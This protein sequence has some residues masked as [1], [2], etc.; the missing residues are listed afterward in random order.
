MIARLVQSRLLRLFSGTVIDQAMLSAVNFLVGLLLIRYTTDADYAS[1]VLVQTA[2]M[3]LVSLQGAW[4]GGPLAV[5]APQLPARER[6]AM[7]STAYFGQRR[8]GRWLLLV[9]A[10]SALGL[11]LSGDIGGIGVTIFAAGSL[12][13]WASMEREFLRTVLLID[14]RAPTLLLVDGLYVLV[15][16]GGVVLAI[17]SPTAAAT[18]AVLAIAIASMAAARLTRRIVTREP[19][20]DRRDNR[21]LW[22]QLR[23]LGGWA[24]AGVVVYWSFSQGYNYLLVLM[25][26]VGAVA[27]VAATRLLLMPVNLL[28][29]GVKNLLVPTVAGWL[30]E[31]GLPTVMRRLGLFSAVMFVLASLYCGVLWLLRDWI[32]GT[33]LGKQIPDRDTL[34]LLWTLIYLVCL[35]RDIWQSALLVRKR[36]RSL[37]RFTAVNAVLSL[38]AIVIGLKLYGAPGALLGLAAGEVMYTVAVFFMLR[39]ELHRV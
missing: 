1:Y 10:V 25:L 36:F 28:T 9:C 35:V 8:Q 27:A 20:W 6:R 33:L 22:K 32:T 37:A 3:L 13:G 16:A 26:D 24:I 7:I 21:S 38:V 29:V 11:S 34:L 31:F 5:L 39:Q 15:L 14:A 18:L 19:T 12:A 23:P 17:L 4:I 30:A 2:V